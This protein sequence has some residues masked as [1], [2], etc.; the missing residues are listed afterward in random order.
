MRI[1]IDMQGAQTA[2]RFRGIGR[3]TMSI[4]KAMIRNRGEHEF[5]LLLNGLFEETLPAIR[6]AFEGLLPS[7]NILTWTTPDPVHVMDPANRGREELAKLLREALIAS[8][9][10][11]MVCIS[12][13][14][15]GYADNAVASIGCFDQRTPTCAIAY[16]FIPLLYPEQYL[17]HSP[18]YTQYY[19]SK[20]KELGRADLLLTISESSRQEAVELLDV[21]ATHVANISAACDPCFKPHEVRPEDHGAMLAKWGIMRRFIL[22]TGG[23]DERKNL[24]RLIEAFSRLPPDL[25]Q[26]HQLL[27]AGKLSAGQQEELLGIARK[28]GLTSEEL[29]FTGFVSDEELVLAYNLCQLFV[30]P[31]WHEG[32]GLPPL[33]AMSCGAPAIAGNTS[34]LPE[35]MGWSEALFD[36]FDLESITRKMAQALGDAGFRREL[37]DHAWRQA[38]NFSWDAC[39]KLAIDAM[40]GVN[41]MR[42]MPVDTASICS[43]GADYESLISACAK[44]LKKHALGSSYDLSSL[45][46]C[47]AR[48]ELEAAHYWNSAGGHLNFAQAPDGKN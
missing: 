48:N 16:D 17:D 19:K 12:S 31:S 25:R 46:A 45:A 44:V 37:I 10:P 5:I 13:F 32:F 9:R 40:Q 38:P 8:L 24:R 35:V 3:Y 41:R 18:G 22:Y 14:F 11:D 7:E 21:D 2:S 1:V 36:P 26:H 4:A 23:A 6:G 28:H 43:D 15:E 47:I 33:E 27:F 30:F 42:Q 20:V 29:C 39:A 34:S